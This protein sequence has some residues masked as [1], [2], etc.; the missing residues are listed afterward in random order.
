MFRIATWN[1]N[2]LRI[3][4][5]HVLDWLDEHEPDVFALQETKVIDEEFPEEELKEAGYNVVYIGQK[6]FNGVAVLSKHMLKAPVFALPNFDD[7]QKRLLAVTAG[8]V[9]VINVY[10]PNGSEVGSD[11]YSYKLKWLQSLTRFVKKQLLSFSNV[12][13]LG[14]F[15]IAPADVDVYDP[16]AW[17]GS[18]L[19]SKQER[20]AFRKLCDLGLEDAFRCGSGEPGFSWWDYRG[21]SLPRNHGLRID[22]ILFSED[23][24]ASFKRC[25]VDKVPRMLERPSDHTPV[26]AEFDLK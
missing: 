20:V 17:Q 3:R 15:N 9:R 18:V 7:E 16:L 1:V 22:H 13:I 8:G 21:G 14:D 6:T 2:S 24:E 26:V 19:V 11:K 5:P 12:I 4:L 10:V 25:F 23:L